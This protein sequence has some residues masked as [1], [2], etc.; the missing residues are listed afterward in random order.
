MFK[1][2]WNENSPLVNAQFVP[3]IFKLWKFP[4]KLQASNPALRRCQGPFHRSCAKQAWKHRCSESIRLR[5]LQANLITFNSAISAAK[6]LG[7]WEEVLSLLE[8]LVSWI[9]IGGENEQQKEINGRC[10]F[11]SI[12]CSWHEQDWP[13]FLGIV[14]TGGWLTK[15]SRPKNRN[16]SLQKKVPCEGSSLWGRVHN[17]SNRKY[18]VVFVRYIYSQASLLK[19]VSARYDSKSLHYSLEISLQDVMLKSSQQAKIHTVYKHRYTH[20]KNFT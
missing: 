1:Y 16:I 7:N 12:W 5:S 17:P 2:V 11:G 3:G 20:R 18:F 4:K 14:D 15:G 13:Y 10:G 8:E 19:F 6:Q 9:W